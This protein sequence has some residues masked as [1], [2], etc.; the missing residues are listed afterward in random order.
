[1]LDTYMLTSLHT[2]IHTDV[3]TYIYITYIHTSYR[4]KHK[5]IYIHT[6][7]FGDTDTLSSRFARGQVSL[8]HAVSL[9][10]IIERALVGAGGSQVCM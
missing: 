5:N 4:H 1:M 10:V 9:L 6:S 3:K 2:H 7:I 8:L